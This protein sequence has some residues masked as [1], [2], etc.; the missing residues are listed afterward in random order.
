MMKK[1]LFILAI[2]AIATNLA[3]PQHAELAPSGTITIDAPEST[4][5]LFDIHFLYDLEA[6]VGANGNAGVIF[7]NDEF[8][9]SA[10]ASDVIHV[11]DVNGNFMESFTIPVLT[12]TRSFTT[13]GTCIYA[14][15][16]GT[17]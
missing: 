3:N 10:W 1:L 5:A 6:T 7:F 13:D 4:N 8:W 2:T 17:Q 14:S 9:V 16:A 12:G 11:L 15:T